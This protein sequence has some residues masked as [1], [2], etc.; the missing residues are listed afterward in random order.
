MK[1]IPYHKRTLIIISCLLT[2]CLGLF[3]TGCVSIE[4][5][6]P[7]HANVGDKIA[8]RDHDKFI[9]LDIDLYAM[10][11]AVLGG[12]KSSSVFMH[13]ER[14]LVVTV[15]DGLAGATQVSIWSNGSMISSPVPFQ[16]DTVPIEVRILA[17]GDSLVS[18]AFHP[19]LLDNMLNENVRPSLVINEGLASE[20]LQ[21]GAMRLETVLS[22]H[23]GVQYIY[24]LEGTND[25]SDY[26]N[27]PIETMLTSLNQMINIAHNAGIS[28]LLAT[29]PPRKDPYLLYDQ[30]SP[31]TEEW[32]AA[33]SAYADTNGI[34]LV[35]LHGAFMAE[36]DWESL[37]HEDG[38]HFSREGWNF[39]AN[40]L[41]SIY[42]PLLQ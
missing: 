25:V 42:L 20:T 1:N 8:I 35:D 37:L 11:G 22:I 30:T 18:N 10:F 13:D 21:G 28:V 38:L 19:Q 24:I 4:T 2:L 9:P 7:H 17:Y 29:I 41:Y 5:V 14:Q 26:R 39:V 40:E 15:P 3:Q 34:Q 16:V 23:N 31:T 6:V 27:T 36:P 12:V 33:L 32:N